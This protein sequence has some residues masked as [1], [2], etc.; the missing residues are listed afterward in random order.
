MNNPIE[1]YIA[2]A[3]AYKNQ[4]DLFLIPKTLG[5]YNIYFR[6]SLWLNGNIWNIHYTLIIE[7]KNIDNLVRGAA[8]SSIREENS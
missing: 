3:I 4:E 1:N 6:L 7:E 2:D 5:N 8:G